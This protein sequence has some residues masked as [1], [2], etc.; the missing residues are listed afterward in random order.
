MRVC[1]KSGIKQLDPYKERLSQIPGII[2]QK[3]SDNNLSIYKDFGVII[4]PEEFG[5]DREVL[6]A[7]LLHEKIQTKK[8][9]YPPL[10]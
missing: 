7:K 4:D 6:A 9:F 3:V 8:Y 10:H 2:F 1:V 5:M